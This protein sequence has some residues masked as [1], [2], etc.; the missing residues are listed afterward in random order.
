MERCP[1]QDQL[2]LHLPIGLSGG[3]RVQQ[4]D[5]PPL[6]GRPHHRG[7]QS[8]AVDHRPANGNRDHHGTDPKHLDPQW[9]RGQRAGNVCLERAYHRAPGRNE[10]LWRDLHAD[11]HCQLRD[12][13][14]G[15]PRDCG[16]RT[17]GPAVR[18]LLHR[19]LSVQPDGADPG[20]RGQQPRSC[21]QGLQAGEHHAADGRVR[22]IRP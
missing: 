14:L 5:R 15:G 12:G 19:H 10:Q 16:I 7:G 1:D 22:S 20:H 17:H 4:H 18:F 9:G 6:C 3:V 11:R 8:H 21:D 13:G 2:Q